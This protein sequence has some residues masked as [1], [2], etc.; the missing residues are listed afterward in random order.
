VIKINL[1]AS[2]QAAP[3]GL[4][5]VA[6][7]GCIIATC[8]IT[9]GYG[10]VLHQSRSTLRVRSIEADTRLAEAAQVIRR[11]EGRRKHHEDLV[12]RLAAIREALDDRTTS[13]DM[14]D[15]VS[16][17]LT[18]GVWLTQIKRSLADV[19]LDGRASSLAEITSLVQQLAANVSFSRGPELRSVSAEEGSDERLLRFQIV[20]HLTSVAEGSQP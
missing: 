13:S 18:D 16:R 5:S 8:V 11:V 6:H 15:L 7:A 4:R 2:G 14:L 12:R 1:L 20:G 19:Q 10:L 17:S 9:A 3:R